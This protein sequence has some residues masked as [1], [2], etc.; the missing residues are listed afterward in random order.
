MP[1]SDWVGTI[2]LDGVSYYGTRDSVSSGSALG[3]WSV[4]FCDE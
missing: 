1:A 4:A 2:G 3:S